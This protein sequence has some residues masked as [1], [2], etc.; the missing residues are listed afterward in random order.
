MVEDCS[1]MLAG[2]VAL[3]AVPAIVRVFLVLLF[4]VVVAV[5][6]R[7]YR[8][9]CNCLVFAVALDDALVRQ[10]TLIDEPVAVDEKELRMYGQFGYCKIHG[11]KRGT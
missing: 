2:G 9:R 7:Q 6:L 11:M 3:V 5:G 4:H 1:I 8:C 10:V